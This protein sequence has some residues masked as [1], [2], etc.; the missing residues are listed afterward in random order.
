M[1]GDLRAGQLDRLEDNGEEGARRRIFGECRQDE[2]PRLAD[3]QADLAGQ[4]LGLDATAERHLRD[5]R[6]P[7]VE[8]FHAGTARRADG[9]IETSG[10]RVLGVTA[11]GRDVAEARRRAY[12]AADKIHFDG[13]QIRRDIADRAL[14]R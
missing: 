9:S 4:I 2:N 6:D 7:D 12:A 5:E 8:V 1:V 14:T 13:A 11:R 3:P 10:G